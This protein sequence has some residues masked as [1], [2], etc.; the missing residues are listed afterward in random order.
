M[1]F[2]TRQAMTLFA[3]RPRIVGRTL[4]KHDANCTPTTSK[5]A[6]RGKITMSTTFWRVVLRFRHWSFNVFGISLQKQHGL[7]SSKF[8]LGYRIAD[9]PWPQGRLWD[10][11]SSG[12]GWLD[13]SPRCLLGG[14]GAEP[15]DC[16]LEL[17]PSNEIL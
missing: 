4:E 3:S 13:F 11:T 9:G 7:S 17:L 15:C 12:Q 16:L 8:L 14:A 2:S 1:I 5:Y 10:C 6:H